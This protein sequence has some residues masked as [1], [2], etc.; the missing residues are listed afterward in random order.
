MSSPA[1]RQLLSHASCSY[2]LV[3][4][5]GSQIAVNFL[6]LDLPAGP[7]GCGDRVTL[8]EPSLEPSAMIGKAGRTFCGQLLP[9]YPGP[10]VL[11]SG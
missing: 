11:V 9:N 4:S 6:E 2:Q 7:G 5:P 3:T 1:T 8:T 10:S